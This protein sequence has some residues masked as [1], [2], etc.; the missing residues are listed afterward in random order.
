[1]DM[2]TIGGTRSLRE[3]DKILSHPGEL[4][5]RYQMLVEQSA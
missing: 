1:M 4:D 5:M 2:D 3:N